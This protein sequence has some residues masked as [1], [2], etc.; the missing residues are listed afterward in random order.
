MQRSEFSHD[1]Y[2]GVEFTCDD[3][4]E[5]SL[6]H[7][8]EET[9]ITI[10]CSK[11]KFMSRIQTLTYSDGY[12]THRIGQSKLKLFSNLCRVSV[13]NAI[14]S[15]YLSSKLEEIYRSGGTL[16]CGSACECN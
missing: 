6:T 1:L 11:E 4:R 7:E 14:Y 5:I 8:D 12:L 2:Q 15:L 9:E 10:E 16:A 3:S 13:T